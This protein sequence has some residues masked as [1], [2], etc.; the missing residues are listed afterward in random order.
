MNIK[1]LVQRSASFMRRYDLLSVICGVRRSHLQQRSAA[2]GLTHCERSSVCTLNDTDKQGLY[3]RSVF[4]TYTSE[5][6][7]GDVGVATA[8]AIQCKGQA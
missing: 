7:I 5:T 2:A 6:R 8:Q 3:I 4:P 1:I